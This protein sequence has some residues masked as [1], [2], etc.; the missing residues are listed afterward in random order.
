KREMFQVPLMRAEGGGRGLVARMPGEGL[1]GLADLP[2]L[3]LTGSLTSL[4]EIAEVGRVR[5]GELH[6]CWE[7]GDPGCRVDS[8]GLAKANDTSVSEVL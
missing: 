4:D 3:N 7:E 1:P 8:E 2:V 6:A 5:R